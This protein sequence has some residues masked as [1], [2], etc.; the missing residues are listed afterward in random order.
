MRLAVVDK[1]LLG[2]VTASGVV[3][4]EAVTEFKWLENE[5]ETLLSV[6]LLLILKLLLLTLFATE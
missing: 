3:L 5:N 6:R 4:L 1:L 2:V